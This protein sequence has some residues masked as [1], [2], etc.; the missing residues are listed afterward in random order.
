VAKA[1]EL[2]GRY[3]LD[4]IST[5]SSIAF[6]MECFEHELI[7]LKET[8]GIELRFGNADA[9]LKMIDLIARRQGLGN[10]LAEGTRHA[11]EV[12]GGNAYAMQVKG[13]SGDDPGKVRGPGLCNLRDGR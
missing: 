8:G 5:S 12:I 1:N 10:V 13:W 3:T 7:G 6:A 4:T 9:M 2:C 11:A